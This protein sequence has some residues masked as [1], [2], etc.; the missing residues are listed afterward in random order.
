M[1]ELA[2]IQEDESHGQSL[3]PEPS[4]PGVPWPP[5]LAILDAPNVCR[6]PPPPSEDRTG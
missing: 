4:P 3:H 6:H 1:G 2:A 5:S